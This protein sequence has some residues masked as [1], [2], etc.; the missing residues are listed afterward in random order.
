MQT[1]SGEMTVDTKLPMLSAPHKGRAGE[2]EL[3]AERSHFEPAEL[4]TPTDMCA[5]AASGDIDRLRVLVQVYSMS[6]DEGDYDQRTA[7]HLAASE[8]SLQA[9]R[10]LVEEF[11]AKLSPIDRWGGTP[12]DDAI[13]GGHNAVA[14][15]LSTQ[16]ARRGA[17]VSTSSGHDSDSSDTSVNS[18]SSRRPSLDRSDSDD[19][20][21]SG[22]RGIP[23]SLPPVDQVVAAQYHMDGDE[24]SNGWTT[25]PSSR[26]T[27]P[28]PLLAPSPP[29]VTAR[30]PRTG[31]TKARSLPAS[32]LQYPYAR[33]TH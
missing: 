29:C 2:L 7:I 28:L 22:S 17:E 1:S 5:A 21:A 10:C 23:S 12:L 6:V 30:K 3:D 25:L 8:G 18:S 32:P 24:P 19:A 4:P 16:G 13:R 9:I 20:V 31:T 33:S 11:H 27:R 15:Y 26:S 14:Q